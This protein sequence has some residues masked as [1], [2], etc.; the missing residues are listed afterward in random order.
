M[1]S[2]LLMLILPL[3]LISCGDI[4]GILKGNSQPSDD[5]PA[6]NT[7]VTVQEGSM[8]KKEALKI[9]V[10]G[11]SIARG[12]GLEDVDTERFSAILK[13]KLANEYAEVS[14]ANYGIDGLT[15]AQLVTKLK[16]EDI[17]ELPDCDYVIVSIGGNNILGQLQ[18]LL[19][20]LVLPQEFDPSV[21]SEYFSYVFSGETDSERAIHVREM[22]NA[23]IKG[24]NDVFESE[25]FKQ[26]V[27]SAGESLSEEI[28]QI[29][30]A[31]KSK[32]PNA[33]I[34]FQT[35]YNPYGNIK[36]SLPGI[37]TVL[38][39]SKYGEFAVSSLNEAIISLAEENGY[40][41]AQVHDEFEK[42]IKPL[43]NAGINL[44]TA[45][46]SVDPHPNADGHKK[47]A[48]IYYKIIKEE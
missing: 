34:L 41:V 39:M 29:V 40:T 13:D 17:K 5:E 36:I 19:G 24:V 23:L 9:L 48:N 44:G 15:G 32:N 22:I 14:V 31:I 33:K 6:I 30:T 42:S 43:T 25:E 47:I 26:M 35:V 2:L 18:N 4:S 7:S 1:V 28:P 46:F 8:D 20:L 45:K 11:D 12:Y 38:D 37:E 3:S 21:F 27:V 16:T 10:L